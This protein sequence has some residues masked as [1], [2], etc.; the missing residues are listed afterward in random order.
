MSKCT[1]KSEKF[2]KDIS[3][4]IDNNSYG[5]KYVIVYYDADKWNRRD[6]VAKITVHDWDSY[7]TE[8]LKKR[9]RNAGA[10]NIIGGIKHTMVKDYLDLAFDIKKSKMKELGI[11]IS[12]SI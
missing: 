7:D 8:L 9:M 3:K 6:Y 2:I 5:I 4:A 12:K 10:T 11:D 1:P